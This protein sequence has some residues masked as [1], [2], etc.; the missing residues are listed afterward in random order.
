MIVTWGI[1]SLHTYTVHTKGIS[2]DEGTLYVGG[3]RT[4]VHTQ[5]IPRVRVHCT[6]EG[7]EPS[8]IH[9]TYRE[10]RYAREG[11]MGG[12]RRGGGVTLVPLRV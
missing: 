3:S 7:R 1:G 6:W 4:L 2:K 5:Y 10:G 12:C 9:S 8:Y 11:H